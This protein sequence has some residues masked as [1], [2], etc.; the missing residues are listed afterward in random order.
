M[1]FGKGGLITII[2][3]RGDSVTLKSRGR[4]HIFFVK[5]PEG[6][7][8]KILKYIKC[9]YLKPKQTDMYHVTFITRDPDDK[10]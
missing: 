6:S 3:G 9:T 4:N 2:E 7:S 1:G 10:K 8:E 5:E